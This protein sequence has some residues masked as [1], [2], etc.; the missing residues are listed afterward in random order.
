MRS[1]RSIAGSMPI[2]T[3]SKKERV[4]A[5]RAPVTRVAS[6]W[7]QPDE[8]YWRGPSARILASISTVNAV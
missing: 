5:T 7:F 2:P 8:R 3:V 4:S 1:I 6:N